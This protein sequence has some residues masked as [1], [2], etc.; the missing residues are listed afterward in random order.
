MTTP[1]N[2]DNK[3]IL[4][5]GATGY[6]GSHT[7]VELLAAGYEVL[8]LDNFCNSNK[9]VLAHILGKATDD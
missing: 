4:L 6:S 7:W 3:M 2:N 9:K 5:T 8:G 1:L